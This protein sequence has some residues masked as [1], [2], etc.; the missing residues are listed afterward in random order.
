MM[1]RGKMD[2]RF[3]KWINGEKIFKFYLIMVYNFILIFYL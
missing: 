3:I 2:L 1:I